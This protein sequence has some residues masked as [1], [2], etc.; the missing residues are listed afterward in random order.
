MP[1]THEMPVPIAEPETAALPAPPRV[2]APCLLAGL[3]GGLLF[4]L[5]YFPVAW[6]LWLGWVALVPWLVLVRSPARPRAVYLSAWLG[7]LVFFVPVLQWMRV[8]DF[9]MYFTWAAL[10]LYCSL[11]PVVAVWLLRRL[12]RRTGL[13]LVLTVP[14]VWVALELVRAH[15][16]TGFAWYF[17]AHTQHDFLAV[18]QV[19][20]VTGVYGVSFLVA[21]VNVVVFE[22]LC[23]LPGVRRFLALPER[24]RLPLFPT[25]F[26][27]A[28][29]AAVLG[30]GFWRLGQSEFA[31]G[32]RVA[33]VQGNVPQRVRNTDGRAMLL[34]YHALS[35]AACKLKPDLVAWPET[36]F[37]EDWPDL[38]PGVD[39]ENAHAVW[40]AAPQDQADLE[41]DVRRLWPTNVLLG[42][43]ANVLQPDGRERRYNSA[44]LFREHGHAGPRYDK[45]HRVPFGEYVPFKD[46]LPF[47]NALSPYDFDYSVSSG[48]GFPRF[49][50]GPYAF[51]VVICYEDTNLTLARQYVTPGDRAVDFLVNVSNDGWF[52][53]TAEHEEHLAACR[54]RAVE[55]RRAVLRAVNMGVSAVIDPNGRVLAPQKTQELPFPKAAA[56]AAPAE[57][58]PVERERMFLWE[59][60]PGAVALPA[61]RWHEFKKV[62]GVLTAVVPVDTR[63]SVYAAWGDWLPWTCW[64]FVGVGLLL[65]AVRRESKER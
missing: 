26:A 65:G 50:L 16:M 23:M 4:Y 3:V 32:P 15:L 6:G 44:L 14:A 8:A 58:E 47:M 25:A 48:E 18:I 49:E 28:L 55:C 5:C 12:D 56:D 64:A 29:L 13:P 2:A 24:A 21:V 19:S 27:A 10:A 63:G 61:R 60:S 20:D 54:F 45:I 53:G 35:S 62:A 37:P 33:L 31:D 59:V 41:R 9:R 38:A 36:S 43:N 17:L 51:G 11:Y 39:L 34:H 7:G 40:K 46:L 52:D 22:W 42:L 57:G 30:Y 1:P